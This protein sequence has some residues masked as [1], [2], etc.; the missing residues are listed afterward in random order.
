MKGLKNLTILMF[1]V[2]F[3]FC[4]V[5]C[6]DG[7]GHN[8]SSNPP[9]TN[10]TAFSDYKGERGLISF[11]SGNTDESSRQRSLGLHDWQLR[12]WQLKETEAFSDRDPDEIIYLE[13]GE[14]IVSVPF[15]TIQLQLIAFA[16]ITPYRQFE[17][18][19]KKFNV[20]NEI[21]TQH[22]FVMVPIEMGGADIDMSVEIFDWD[23]TS[24]ISE[25]TL[26][27]EIDSS[28]PKNIVKYLLNFQ[29]LPA[30]LNEGSPVQL[31][32]W[33]GEKR[34]YS[35]ESIRQDENGQWVLRGEWREAG[36]GLD[37]KNVRAYAIE[38]SPLPLLLLHHS[39]LTPLSAPLPRGV[40]GKK[41]LV[42]EL[43]SNPVAD[44]EVSQIA[45]TINGN[46]ID[47]DILG[48]NL[49]YGGYHIEEK[50][51]GNQA[52]FSNLHLVIPKTNSISITVQAD[53]SCQA[54][55][56]DKIRLSIYPEDIQI[57]EGEV[58]GVCVL[59]NT[60]TIVKSPNEDLNESGNHGSP[61]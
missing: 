12:I 2:V 39:T 23:I 58:A 25:A 32:Y 40:L 9:V 61:D 22:K 54:E 50:V 19:C 56:G 20:A 34:W 18:P 11:T 14:G 1:L 57:A 48:I 3:C 55:I 13:S 46:N 37:L 31:V 28:V 16:G 10:Y 38:P 26:W 30:D 35:Y 49:E 43:I 60:M 27:H 21:I 5:G 6:L 42:F 51:E 45:I 41:F 17:S 24:Y 44:I 7:D 59:G 4:G 47:D 8:T 33:D 52:I 36:Q 29:E 53:I 15:G